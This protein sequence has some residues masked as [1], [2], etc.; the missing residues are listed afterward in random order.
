VKAAVLLFAQSSSQTAAE[1]APELLGQRTTGQCHDNTD[2]AGREQRLD[3]PSPQRHQGYRR[4]C[5]H[6]YLPS[7]T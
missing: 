7:L 2:Q 1:E 4:G 6:R 5:E 3:D